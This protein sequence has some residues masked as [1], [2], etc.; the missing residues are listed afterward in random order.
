MGSARTIVRSKNKEHERPLKVSFHQSF[1]KRKFLSSLYKL[2]SDSKFDE[3]R[4]SHDMC[5]ADRAENG[6]LLQEAYQRN[7]KIKNAG[8][9]WKVR[10]PPWALRIVKVF[11]KN[12]QVP[13]P[14][15]Q[16]QEIERQ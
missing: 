11:A 9:K 6:R 14:M 10:G 3:I 7:Q 5:E 8:Y 1:D 12:D 15:N 16:P 13:K 4:V 2:K